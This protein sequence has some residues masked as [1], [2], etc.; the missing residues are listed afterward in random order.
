MPLIN[1]IKEQRI[2]AQRRERQVQVAL[3]ATLGIG[4]LCLVTTAGLMLDGARLN[5]RGAALEQQIKDLEPLVAELDQNKAE[6][7]VMQPKVKTL[8][9]A[10]TASAQWGR[11]L[12]HMTTN[13]PE[14][15]WLTNVKAF[16]QDRTK[17][18][19]L[20]F[21][22]VS[23]SQDL[24]GDLILRL[25]LSPDLEKA[26]LKYTQPRPAEGQTLTEFE[27]EAELVGSGEQSEEPAEV[28]G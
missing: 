2:E 26:A 3:M 9:E 5:M 17:P 27:V 8:E 14:G 13:T 4:A 11:V 6:I 18:M 7:A 20:T 28:N 22:G 25:E 19:V 15:T 24:V 23:K 21:K 12:A 1:L 16:Q 10:Q